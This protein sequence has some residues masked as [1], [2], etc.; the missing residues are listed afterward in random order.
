MICFL[1]LKA[2]IDVMPLRS[3]S[4]LIAELGVWAD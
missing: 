2:G 4:V 3:C 1:V